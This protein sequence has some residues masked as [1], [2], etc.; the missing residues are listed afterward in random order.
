MVID[1]QPGPKLKASQNSYH[2]DRLLN[3]Q[4]SEQYVSSAYCKLMT[5]VFGLLGKPSFTPRA[6][7]SVNIML[8]P[9]A[10][11]VNISGDNRSPCLSPCRHLI[12]LPILPLMRIWAFADLSH[13]SI[14]EIH[15]YPNLCSLRTSRRHSQLTV[16]YAFSKSSFSRY[17]FCAYRLH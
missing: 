3:V 2:L 15:R 7:V 14:P 1:F 10:T 9:S 17:P 16:S 12:S 11:N 5:L 8:S 13:V 6:T 4:V